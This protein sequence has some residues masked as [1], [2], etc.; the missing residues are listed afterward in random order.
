MKYYLLILITLCSTSFGF[1]Q[2]INQPQ[3][4]AP[5]L[6]WQRAEVG[7][8]ISYDLPVFRARHTTRRKIESRLLTTLIFLT[9]H[10]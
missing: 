3:P 8:L 5:Q 9:Q 2:E 1:A 10:S 7:V 6:A 4:T